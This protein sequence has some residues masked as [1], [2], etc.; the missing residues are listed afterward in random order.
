MDANALGRKDSTAYVPIWVPKN[1][2]GHAKNDLDRSAPV[3]RTT[4][5]H[6]GKSKHIYVLIC[7]LKNQ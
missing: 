5:N 7:V 3:S 6:F 1:M 2:E 4:F